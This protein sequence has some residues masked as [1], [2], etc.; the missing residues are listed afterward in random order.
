MTV[1]TS[2]KL[3]ILG[4]QVFP[5]TVPEL[6]ERIADYIHQNKKAL[7]LH[8]NVHCLNLAYNRPWLRDFLNKAQVVLCDGAG[9]MLGARLLNHFIPERITYADWMWQF[10]DF[11]ESEE[12]SLFFLGAR[13]GV[14]A[15][16]AQAMQERFPR[17][18]IAGTHHGY[19]DKTPG[20]AE[21]EAVIQQINTL[22]PNVL[23]IGFGMPV[24]E[25]WLLQ[26]WE[27]L[28]VNIALTGG[29]VFDY[30]SGG[31]SRAPR[32]MTSNGLEWLGRL[33]I[34]PRRLWKRYVL[35]NPVFL[36]RILKQRFG[37]LPTQE[38]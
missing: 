11:V 18:K 17:L 34:E 3:Y 21:N 23:V 25:R 37:Y 26:N 4:V 30:I 31:L 19:F 28:N 9:V 36:W 7:V 8:V 27:A 13:P 22:K 5:M 10:G 20:S 16:A 38:S 35:G 2:D 15:A 29:A 14:A 1:K 32:W 33:L 12:F 24:Q 6:H